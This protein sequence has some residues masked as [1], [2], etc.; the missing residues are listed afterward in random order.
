MGSRII[1]SATY[2]IYI[3]LY[4]FGTFVPKKDIDINKDITQLQL[5]FLLLF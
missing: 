5:L 3:F 1:E 4:I 2:E